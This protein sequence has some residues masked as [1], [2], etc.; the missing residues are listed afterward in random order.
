MITNRLQQKSVHEEIS[1]KL[2]SLEVFKIF[3]GDQQN[4]RST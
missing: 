2:N 3:L 1:L 4:S